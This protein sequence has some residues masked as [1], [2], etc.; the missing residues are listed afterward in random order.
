MKLMPLK[1][2]C[3]HTQVIQVTAEILK[4]AVP[5]V[6][7][8]LACFKPNQWPQAPMLQLTILQQK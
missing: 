8:D 1:C 5:Q 3:M 4:I 6:A 7:T 2:L